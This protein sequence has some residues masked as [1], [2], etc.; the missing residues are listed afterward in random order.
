[1][2]PAIATEH[3]R[4]VFTTRFGK[5]TVIAV[6]D[7]SLEIAPGEV[8]GFLGRNGA[9]KTTAVM[10]LLGC[11]RPTSGSARL[12]GEPITR[13]A[14]RRRVGFLPEKFRFHEFLTPTELM[15]VHG[16]LAGMSDADVRRRTPE[17]LE[18][19]GLADRAETPIREFSKGMQQRVGLAQA[20][21]ADPALLVLD[22]PTS[23]LDPLGR[24]EVRD[25]LLH[26]KAQ[27]KTVFLNSHLLSEV[28]LCCDRVAI[29][30]E[31]RVV[32]EGRIQ[33]LL[34]PASTYEVRAT[35]VSDALRER[36]AEFGRVEPI[37][38]DPDRFRVTLNDGEDA[39]RLVAALVEGGAALHAFIPQRESLEEFFVRTVEETNR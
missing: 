34:A 16:R 26:L 20:L 35:H 18:L 12:F 15:R 19:V 32:Q 14:S 27:G 2:P 13:P 17:V 10:M 9:G 28:E 22:E 3:L 39:P 36:L 31:G 1:M 4:K 37:D 29:L 6:E 33:D 24:R 11:I 8:F 21:I 5:R 25:L 30:N 38:G 7:L 23:A